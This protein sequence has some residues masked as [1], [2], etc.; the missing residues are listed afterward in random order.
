M[1]TRVRIAITIG[2]LWL[3]A[4]VVLTIV[5]ITTHGRRAVHVN[6]GTINL[7]YV[8]SYDWASWLAAFAVVTTLAVVGLAIT[9][10]WTGRND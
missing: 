8:N 3:V 7:H 10:V 6:D 9:W 2:A 5:T 4:V 1:T